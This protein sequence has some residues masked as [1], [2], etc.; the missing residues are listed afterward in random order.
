[1][2]PRDH[3]QSRDLSLGPARRRNNIV[4]K[5]RAGMRGTAFCMALGAIN[6]G[7]IFSMVLLEIDAAGFSILEFESYA[8]WPVDVYRITLWVKPVQGM[9]VKNRAR[10][11]LQD[12]RQDLGDPAARRFACAFSRRSL[13][14]G[15]YSTIQKETCF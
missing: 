5:Q 12:A 1:M 6:H 2:L 10:S 8:P 9:K 7:F 11:S 3:E 4:T 13:S 15:P 14:F